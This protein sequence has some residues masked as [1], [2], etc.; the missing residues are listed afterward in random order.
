MLT[1]THPE[2]LVR[3]LL[4]VWVGGVLL[5]GASAVAGEKMSS[6]K[7][8]EPAEYL[9]ALRLGW[10]FFDAGNLSGALEAFE[11]ALATEEGRHAAEAHYALSA[12]WWQRRN[13]FA[14]HSR[15]AEALRVRE[16]AW[17][18]NSGVDNEWDR[19][20]ESRLRYISRNFSSVRL[21][22][23]Q[24]PR[25]LAPLPDPAPRD[26]LLRSF[27]EA[28]LGESGT[29]PVLADGVQHVFLPSGSYWVGNESY[30]LEPGEL[31]PGQ[32]QSWDLLPDRGR[33]R[34]AHRER[35]AAIEAEHG[36]SSRKSKHS[37][38][39]ARTTSP[40]GSRRAPPP[41]RLPTSQ[42]GA[43]QSVVVEL[44]PM[45]EDTSG[46][47]AESD[48]ERSPVAF[49][50]QPAIEFE[51]VRSYMA[52]SVSE[53]IGQRWR[54]P[55]FHLQYVISC[56]SLDSEHGFSFPDHDFYVRVDPG[57]SLRVRGAE[58]LT[59]QL[60]SDWQ[61]GDQHVLNYVDI[62]FDGTH[63]LVAVNGVEFG[64]VRVLDQPLDRR[65]GRWSIRIGD[66]KARISH[67]RVESWA[68]F[69]GSGP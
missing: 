27:L 15:L 17:A 60:R 24:A 59:V 28:T 53:E 9:Y 6:Q 40:E 25:A 26:P 68:G 67:L 43:V 62:W 48:P 10:S 18:W 22:P 64:P 55:T 13:A 41:S 30:T 3:F 11:E 23:P 44:R 39:S 58:Q 16:E 2:G 33:F 69:R 31:A 54:A 8:K 35:L 34:R 52:E 1:R 63:V 45:G 50:S 4:L 20:I 65:D 56:P 42:G 38:R 29:V 47:L 66:S 61:V 12:V 49:V 14:A 19:R 46:G 32:A 5:H 37:A 51:V 7:A 36:A 57:G 21:R